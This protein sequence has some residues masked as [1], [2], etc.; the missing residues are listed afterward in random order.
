MLGRGKH[1]KTNRQSWG[2]FYLPRVTADQGIFAAEGVEDIFTAFLR[3]MERYTSR[4]IPQPMYDHPDNAVN[5]Y[6][7]DYGLVIV[8]LD[9]DG[10]KLCYSANPR[11]RLPVAFLDRVRSTMAVMPSDIIRWSDDVFKTPEEVSARE[12]VYGEKPEKPPRKLTK[13]E[14]RAKW[15]QPVTLTPE[16]VAYLTGKSKTPPAP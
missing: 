9:Q 1:H 2:L 11:N 13:A 12:V 16:E 15:A 8:M 3:A 7:K 14:K 5:S 6:V 10:T 4:R